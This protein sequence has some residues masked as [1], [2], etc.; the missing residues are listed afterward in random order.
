MCE[1]R[2]E[3]RISPLLRCACI[4][5]STCR[6]RTYALV[7]ARSTA[8]VRIELHVQHHLSDGERNL[9]CNPHSTRRGERSVTI[10]EEGRRERII[11][12]YNDGAAKQCFSKIIIYNVV[13]QSNYV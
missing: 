9:P 5:T 10:K 12:L 3:R 1:E 8:F 4:G 13:L 2:R 11:P 6:V 7:Y